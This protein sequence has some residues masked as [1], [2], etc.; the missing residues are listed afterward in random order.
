MIHHG[1][2]VTVPD[3]ARDTMNQVKRLFDSQNCNA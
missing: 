1:P 3:E 2:F